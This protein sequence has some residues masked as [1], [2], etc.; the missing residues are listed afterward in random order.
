MLF[1]MDRINLFINNHNNK[2]I[3]YDIALYIKNHF[4]DVLS[5][6]VT[7]LAEACHV[8]QPTISRFCKAIGYENFIHFKDE[9]LLYQQQRKRVITYEHV[10]LHCS[11]HTFTKDLNTSI[12]NISNALHKAVLTL[13]INLVEKLA[14]N[15]HTCKK[16][17]IMGMSYSHL[18]AEHIQ[19]ELSYMNKQVYMLNDSSDMNQVRDLAKD[20]LFI[21]ISMYQ[22]FFHLDSRLQHCISA[23]KSQNWLITS[24]SNG[25][26]YS[27]LFSNIISIYNSNDLFVNRYVLLFLVDILI[28][29][30]ENQSL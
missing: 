19:M 4:D 7:E 29:C 14:K 16:I 6:T 9:C 21:L 8:S 2:G 10:G 3:N 5:M 23:N 1:L 30:F 26:N 18:I 11:P 15:L 24:V 17:Y 13:D 22:N 20:D 27:N 25:N 12:N 28:S